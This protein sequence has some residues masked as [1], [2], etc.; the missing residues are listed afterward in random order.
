MSFEQL[1]EQLPALSF[2][3]RQL[4]I[5]RALDLDEVPLSRSDEAEIDRR[6]EAHRQNPELAISFDALKARVRTHFT[7]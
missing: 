3:Q 7:K 6:L 1:L 2:E 5:R 4:L